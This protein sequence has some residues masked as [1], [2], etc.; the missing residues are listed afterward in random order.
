[1]RQALFACV[2]ITTR[3]VVKPTRETTL[4]Y[5][6]V[7]WGVNGMTRS[8]SITSE[9]GITISQLDSFYNE[10]RLKRRQNAPLTKPSVAIRSFSLIQWDLILS[11]AGQSG[12]SVGSPSSKVTRN[13]LL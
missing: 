1:M 4:E 13:G 3:M 10:I 2:S 9:R 8:V 11:Y 5:D 6:S 7:L 12:P